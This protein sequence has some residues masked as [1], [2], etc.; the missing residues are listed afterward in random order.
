[1]NRTLALLTLF[2]LLVLTAS[3]SADPP[4]WENE[5]VLAR[6]RLPPR[7]SFVPFAD[8]EEAR[9]NIDRLSGDRCTAVDARRP[10]VGCKAKFPL[11]RR[12]FDKLFTWLGF[13]VRRLCGCFKENK[14][15]N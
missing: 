15:T 11:S 2:A 1:M 4:D 12:W 5:Q 10:R 3:A 9:V 6:N 14:T 13:Q 8:I 7:A